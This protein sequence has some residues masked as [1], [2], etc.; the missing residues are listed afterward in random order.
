MPYYG[1]Y[2]STVCVATF[3][4]DSNEKFT[5]DSLVISILG[6]G[7]PLGSTFGWSRGCCSI[8][9][10]FDLHANTS[11]VQGLGPLGGPVHGIEDHIVS[12]LGTDVFVGATPM[13]GGPQAGNNLYHLRPAGHVPIELHGEWADSLIDGICQ[14]L[15]CL[16]WGSNV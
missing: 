10:F 6:G 7:D 13:H 9:G 2:R 11:H 1:Y 5:V 14:L 12:Q 8:R 15:P 16:W 4:N 3:I